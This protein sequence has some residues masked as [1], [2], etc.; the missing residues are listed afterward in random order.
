MGDVNSQVTTM[1]WNGMEW[2]LDHGN[3][4]NLIDELGIAQYRFS[5]AIYG[6]KENKMIRRKD[7]NPPDHFGYD[8][9]TSLGDYYNESRYLIITRLGKIRNPEMYPSYREIWRFTPQD[10]DKLQSD[11][12]V[13]RVYTNGDF[14]T[15]LTRPNG[16]SR[17]KSR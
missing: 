14:E 12:T 13:I 15:Y 16:V 9:R 1:E 5:H 6:W 7:T 10:F 2:L 11:E 8:N 3:K 17:S 4:Q